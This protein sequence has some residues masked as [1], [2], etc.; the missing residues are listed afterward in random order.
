MIGNLRDEMGPL[1]QLLSPKDN[2]WP[3]G[4]RQLIH[5]AQPKHCW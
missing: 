1:T 2:M 3:E 4:Q 5:S